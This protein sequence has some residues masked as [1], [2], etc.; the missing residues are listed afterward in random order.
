[1]SET[2]IEKDV[3]GHS[4]LKELRELVESV[5]GNVGEF[6]AEQKQK[7]ERLQSALDHHEAKNQ[8]ITLALQKAENEK[9]EN[10]ERIE[11][12]EKKVSFNALS[13][14]ID[15]KHSEEYKALNNLCMKGETGLS[16]EEKSLLRTDVGT[17]G[18]YLVPE[19]LENEILKK[20]EEV[21]TV[22]SLARVRKTKTKS[23]DIPV[24]ST[25]P[26]AQ[27]FGEAEDNTN[28]ES[29]SYIRET[30]TAHRHH[31]ITPITHE[32]L[33]FA[34]FDMESEMANDAVLAFAKSEGEKF[35]SGTGVKQPEGILTA[36]G[37]GTNDV[38]FIGTDAVS[39]LTL[40][41]VIKLA[42][43]LKEGFNPTYFFNRKTL[44]QLR[45][46]QSASGGYLWT[47]GGERMPSEING[48]RYVIMQDMPDI[49][50]G[51]YAVGFGD[52][53]MGYNILDALDI[54]LIRD[55]LTR[56][57]EDIVEFSWAKHV[58]GRVVLGEA[59]KLLKI[60]E[61]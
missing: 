36:A 5:K 48:F 58:D 10:E 25:I 49:A 57:G 51:A 21:S 44:Y 27:F 15:Y 23:L 16:L 9:K 38:N 28:D 43:E 3:Q 60:S 1:M 59:I 61:A 12:L 13:A 11:A 33:S 50:D 46:E 8:E 14:P 29:S 39:T 34:Q 53:F 2:I 30:M 7:E 18:A 52:L 32:Q 22:R 24:R 55:D 20:V 41:D 42:G 40:D 17:Q 54:R 31:I 56:K 35:I 45:I 26:T 19:M 37:T 4:E 6:T 47:L